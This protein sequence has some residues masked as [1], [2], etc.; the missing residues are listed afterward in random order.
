MAD[1]GLGPVLGPLSLYPLAISA[2]SYVPFG[3]FG[4]I[5]RHFGPYRSTLW[6]TASV[7][8]PYRSTLWPS[9]RLATYPS[10]PYRVGTPCPRTLSNF[11]RVATYPLGLGEVRALETF[12]F[13]RKSH[14]GG[15]QTSFYPENRTFCVPEPQKQSFPL[16]NG[17]WKLQAF[18]LKSSRLNF[19]RGPKL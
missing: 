3:R 18:C 11:S 19:T 14:H 4:P 1:K 15:F 7:G 10:Y 17:P 16:G 5:C 12:I 6:P 8:G 13:S 9:R 2:L